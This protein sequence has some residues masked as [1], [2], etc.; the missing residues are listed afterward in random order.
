MRPVKGLGLLVALTIALST[1][2]VQPGTAAADTTAQ[3]AIKNLAWANRYLG[4]CDMTTLGDWSFKAADGY[5][6]CANKSQWCGIFASWVWNRSGHVNMAQLPGHS[7][8]DFERYGNVSPAPGHK[9]AVGDVVIFTNSKRS[10]QTKNLSHIAIVYSVD[11]SAL[12]G[13]IAGNEGPG[14]GTVQRRYFDYT[15][16]TS[17]N[18]ADALWAYEYVKPRAH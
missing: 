4:P 1:V 12:I 18:P 14:Y 9:P 6:S 2:A 10:D 16:G 13:T 8:S 5:T 15:T 11:S 3:T 7:P 17:T